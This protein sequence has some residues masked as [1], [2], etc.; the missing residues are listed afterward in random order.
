MTLT[1]RSEGTRRLPVLRLR[2][3]HGQLTC[4]LRFQTSAP[5]PDQAGALAFIAGPRAPFLRRLRLCQRQQPLPS[6]DAP[7]AA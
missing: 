2:V 1:S 3:M 7:R 5:R 4:L 6:G